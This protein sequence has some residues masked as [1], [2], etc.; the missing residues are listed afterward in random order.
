MHAALQE[1]IPI[2]RDEEDY[3]AAEEDDHFVTVFLVF[4]FPLLYVQEMR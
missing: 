4:T 1:A 2:F 3:F